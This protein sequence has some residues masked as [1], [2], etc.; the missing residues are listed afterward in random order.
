MLPLSGTASALSHHPSGLTT[1]EKDMKSNEWERI[2][3]LL[4]E[5]RGIEDGT[6]PHVK[7]TVE[8]RF[9]ECLMSGS[10]DLDLSCLGLTSLPP[11]LPSCVKNLNASFNCLTSIPPGV[12]SAGLEV[13]DFSHNYFDEFPDL[14]HL[15]NL[16]Q[17]LLC[18]NKLTH[19]P[20]VNPGLR[21]LYASNNCI[22]KQPELLAHIIEYE[23]WGNP[24]LYGTPFAREEELEGVDKKIMTLW[25]SWAESNNNMMP[26]EKQWVVRIVR[27]CIINKE[28]TLYLN[29]CKMK[30]VPPGGCI[31]GHVK[32]LRLDF[33]ELMVLPKNFFT[34]GLTVIDVSHNHLYSLP[35]IKHLR[36][37]TVLNA[38]YNS[39]RVLPELNPGQ[40]S[41]YANNN[42][43]RTKII[44]P[45][46]LIFWDLNYN[47]KE[48]ICSPYVWC[49]SQKNIDE[50]MKWVALLKEYGA[51][52][53]ACCIARISQPRAA[54]FTPFEHYFYRQITLWRESLIENPAMRAAVFREAKEGCNDSTDRETLILNRLEQ[55]RLTYSATDMDK[56]KFLNLARQVF[57]LEQ[58]ELIADA[59]SQVL[60]EHDP[61]F[62]QELEVYLA[63]Q[64]GLRTLVGP[65]NDLMI[66]MYSRIVPFSRITPAD[67]AVAQKKI[68][69]KER[70][71]FKMWLS[72]WKIA[73]QWFE[74]KMTEE[75]KVILHNRLREETVRVK[76]SLESLAAS[77]R[78]EEAMT[79]PMEQRVQKVAA[80]WVYS[81]IVGTYWPDL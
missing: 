79:E 72:Y 36:H 39:L 12:L 28:K 43:I 80:V 48:L 34:P 47:V 60:Y 75:E 68:E 69:D 42:K 15:E 59:T 9:G 19:L 4:W 44:F 35:E 16:Q 64:E 30:T 6:H 20:A 46:S 81:K 29:G 33:N 65:G 17:A 58:L 55:A 45:E 50:E 66:S 32:I 14:S 24:Y 70:N 7:Y 67:I 53:F 37:L 40:R 31:P 76:A 23:L 2:G 77:A 78:G 10:P 74:S 8:V 27:Q 5:W 62:Q 26:D 25:L 49:L 56:H 52:E 57:R 1:G 3:A 38:E 13:I 18:H 63:Y 22:D 41:L 21:Y 61:E 11:G 73:Q 71:A 54:R 51:H